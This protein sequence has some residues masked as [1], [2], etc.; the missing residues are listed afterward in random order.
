MEPHQE[1]RDRLSRHLASQGLRTALL[2][3]S[4]SVTWLTGFADDGS[5]SP[6]VFT[7]G[8][9]TLSTVIRYMGWDVDSSTD[10]VLTHLLGVFQV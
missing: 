7:G 10:E 3:D 1:Q 9:P 6:A 4:V 2:R 5:V 8:P